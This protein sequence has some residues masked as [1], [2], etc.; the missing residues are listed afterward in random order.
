MLR[1]GAL[2]C[3]MMVVEERT[4]GAGLGADSIRKGG[5][6]SI[7][8]FSLVLLFMFLTYGKL[9]LFADVTLILNVVF[10][11]AGLQLSGATLTLPGIAGIALNIGM[12]VD[13]NI[14]VFERMRV[15][16]ALGIPT[17]RVVDEGFKNALSSI[18]DSNI[19]T[20]ASAFVLFQFGSGSVKGFAITLTIGILTSFFTNITCLKTFLT[21]WAS[22]KKTEKID[23]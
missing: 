20:L 11:F 12:A 10:I 9:G 14:L 1:S 7:L 23:I 19:T 2:P 13:A 17:V 15:L 4:V 3:Q 16:V 21:L 8:G 18:I 6:A 22:K 5:F